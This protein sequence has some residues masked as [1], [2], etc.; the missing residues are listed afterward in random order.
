MDA[1]ALR[2]LDAN[3]NRAREA[4]RVLEEHARLVLDDAA[5]SE[6]AR[7]LRHALAEPGLDPF[8][9][10][11]ARDIEHDVGTDRGPAADRPRVD[12][13]DVARAAAKR[14]TESL[15]C[16][17]EYGKLVD[18]AAARRIERLRYDAYAL[19][20]AV[21]T[22]GPRRARLRR[23]RLHV[24]VT[25]A[26]CEGPWLAVARKALRGGADVLQLR[27]K[28]LSDAEYLDRARQLRAPTLEAGALLI[29]ND[30][31]DIARLAGADGVHLGQPD[32]P[33]LDA[34]Q[35]VGPHALIGRSTHS[36]AEAAAAFEERPDYVAVGPMFPSQTKPDAVVRGL[37]LLTEVA[38]LPAARSAPGIR[39]V[40]IGGITP[41]NAASVLRAAGD[42]EVQLAVCRSV[43]TR[44]DPAEAV[45]SFKAAIENRA[46]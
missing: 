39:L 29:V 22:G 37:P 36:A 27:E 23:A 30:R 33:V 17:E 8:T 9:L 16:L 38:A 26:L 7:G 45:R 19:E 5:L 25:D 20:Q 21:F 31:P 44:L 13:A 42:V 24:L 35:I 1:R 12:S 32:L 15:R 4:L 41:D 40:A 18:P 6:R 10:L 43:I 11:A 34:R 46:S 2:I 28:D 14:L 3:L